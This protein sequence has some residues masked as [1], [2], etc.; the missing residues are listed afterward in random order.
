M[1]RR[2]SLRSELEGLH[3]EVGVEGL[4]A[5]L[6]DE[7]EHFARRLDVGAQD[8][9]ALCELDDQSFRMRLGGLIERVEPIDPR[10][11]ARELER[12]AD[13][14]AAELALQAR[15]H[16]DGIEL[17]RA[18]LFGPLLADPDKKIVTFDL[19]GAEV[20]VARRKLVA[21]KHATRRF[22]DLTVTA[23]P[24]ALRF[25]WRGGR[26]GLNLRP[27]RV[28]PQD[29]VLERRVVLV[30]SAVSL[31]DVSAPARPSASWLHALVVELAALT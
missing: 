3:A 23:D 18:L 10:E 14:A 4:R 29:R 17:D 2:P 12:R 1:P 30:P 25:R 6:V 9:V 24:Q 15:F 22:T 27:L 7:A 20:S 31:P 8:V 19:G 21:V 28:R 16:H 26:G 5:V 11:R 13:D